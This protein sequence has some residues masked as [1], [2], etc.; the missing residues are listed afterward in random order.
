MSAPRGRP[1]LPG[2]RMGQ[3]RP[4]GSRNK[5][6]SPV[7]QVLD[8]YGEPV[9]RKCTSMALQGNIA[10]MRMFLDRILPARR[11]AGIRLNMP[12]TR[13]LL[14]VDKAGEK[15]T[16]GMK[17]GDMT[18]SEAETMMKVL[19]MKGEMVERGPLETRLKKEE[20]CRA[21]EDNG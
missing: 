16:Q 17:R 21:A 15:V 6:A 19:K 12:P 5:A 14:D 1:F 8:Q 9:M 18:P 20:D 7:Q 2:N 3:G 10:A 11:D 4:K 13:T